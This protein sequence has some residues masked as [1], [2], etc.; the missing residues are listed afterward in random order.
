MRVLLRVLE[1]K[2]AGLFAAQSPAG[3]NGG[4]KA[5]V[6][7]HAEAL[8]ARVPRARRQHMHKRSVHPKRQRIDRS[9]GIGDRPKWLL[10]V[11]VLRVGS[12]DMGVVKCQLLFRSD[13][14][15]PYA[16]HLFDRRV[17][18]VGVVL[19]VAGDCK[20]SAEPARRS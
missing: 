17:G 3:V 1:T 12:V 18:L 5:G 20:K 16:T 15:R 8:S 10:P 11:D 4:A 13:S 2:R 19:R 7:P 6:W 9:G 14:V